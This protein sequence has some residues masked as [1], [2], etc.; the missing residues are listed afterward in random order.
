MG[1]NPED[2]TEAIIEGNQKSPRGRDAN[3]MLM[4][5]KTRGLKAKDIGLMARGFTSGFAGQKFNWGSYD[6]YIFGTKGMG[7]TGA[8]VM[9]WISA[10]LPLILKALA[11]V[12]S[13]FKLYKGYQESGEA[14][15]EIDRLLSDGWVTQDD[16][17]GFQ[18]PRPI[19]LEVKN[20][21]IPTAEINEEAFFDLAKAYLEQNSKAK[22]IQDE[23]KTDKGTAEFL[24]KA[25]NVGT[26]L[27][28]TQGNTIVSLVKIDPNRLEPKDD[29]KE[30]GFGN[31]VL[32]IL[33]GVGVLMALNKG[34]KM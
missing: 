3:Y 15:R 33:I 23:A 9:A 21:Q 13:L 4:V 20:F 6:T 17:L 28:P 26:T 7:L 34:K 10:N 27:Q 18:S 24:K 14:K 29:L 25:I 30:A 11:L 19:P 8:E 1:G 2:L 12:G 32:P 31:A 5:A 22:E 16:Y